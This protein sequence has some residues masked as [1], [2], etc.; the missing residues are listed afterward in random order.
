M[1][2]AR[3][4][5][6][7]LMINYQG[8]RKNNVIIVFDAY[9]V[10]RGQAEVLREHDLFIVFTKEAETADAYIEKTTYE[11]GRRHRVRVATSDNAESLIILGHGAL[12]LSARQ[13]HDEVESV[14][15]QI[16][17]IVS[18]SAQRG[19]SDALRTAL[20]RAGKEKRE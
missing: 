3:Q 20:E 18:K 12:R 6:I 8:F 4:M 1:D 9:K 15:G 13:F 10:P 2:T 19:G 17:D 16:A 5:L 14:M 11:L 7:D